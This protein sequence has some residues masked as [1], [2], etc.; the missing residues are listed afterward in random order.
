[1]RRGWG[2]FKETK[3]AIS[4]INIPTQ[5]GRELTLVIIL[6]ARFRDN[7][8]KKMTTNGPFL[9]AFG[10]VIR[11][12]VARWIFGRSRDAGGNNLG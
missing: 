4:N 12:H 8:L 7:Y 1:M 10:G 6:Q 2:H 3:L 5:D 11:K 9:G